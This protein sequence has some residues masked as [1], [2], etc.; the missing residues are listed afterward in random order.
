MRAKY[1]SRVSP[2]ADSFRHTAS[3]ESH[4]ET[5]E[6][7]PSAISLTF[8]FMVYFMR[9]VYHGLPKLET[10]MEGKRSGSVVCV[11]PHD[12][13]LSALEGEQRAL[14]SLMAARRAGEDSRDLPFSFLPPLLAY[15]RSGIPGTIEIGAPEEIG[16][17]IVRPVPGLEA[18]EPIGPPPGYPPLPRGSRL[19]LGFAGGHGPEILEAYLAGIPRDLAGVIVLRVWRKSTLVYAF[20]A[21]PAGLSCGYSFEGGVWERAK[22]Q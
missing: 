8:G 12:S 14:R 9:A 22:G 3:T 2:T 20:E 19:I 7:M 6:T 11:L 1:G 5:T 15:P 10:V 21:G 17:W 13:V 16:G 4:D 18:V